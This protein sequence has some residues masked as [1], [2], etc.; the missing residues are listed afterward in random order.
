MLPSNSSGQHNFSSSPTGV[1]YVAIAVAICR[2]DSAQRRQ[3]AAQRLQ[4]SL[5]NN[6][7]SVSLG[8][9][10]WGLEYRLEEGGCNTQPEQ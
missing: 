1:N 8:I 2:Q 7:N 6:C 4:R 9:K 5:D 3:D 10:A